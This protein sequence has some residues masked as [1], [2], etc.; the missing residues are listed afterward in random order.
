L[1]VPL[2]HLF[3]VEYT[4][5]G[6]FFPKQIRPGAAANGWEKLRDLLIFTLR[7]RSLPSLDIRW[8]Q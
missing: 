6:R 1:D 8:L 4:I 7:F 3:R 2:G 5:G